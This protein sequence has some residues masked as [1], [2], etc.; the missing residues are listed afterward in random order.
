VT[1]RGA[2]DTGVLM[3]S[4]YRKVDSLFGDRGDYCCVIVR[5][6]VQGSRLVLTLISYGVGH[7]CHV[8]VIVWMED[9]QH[10]RT[11]A[12]GSVD[13]LF[14]VLDWRDTAV[15]CRLKVPVPASYTAS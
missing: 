15:A 5:F 10:F 12:V 1:C 2:D 8:I 14:H 13:L 6:K 3:F 9:A 11:R 7:V 4:A